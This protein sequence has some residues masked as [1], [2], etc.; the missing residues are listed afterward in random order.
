MPDTTRP[1]KG[2]GYR[3]WLPAWRIWLYARALLLTYLLIIPLWFLLGYSTAPGVLA[4]DFIAFWAAA[5]L[6]AQG[7]ATLA[8]DP[9]AIHAV[10]LLA[11][12]DSGE[13]PWFYPPPL[14]L[15]LWPLHALDYPTAFL[16]FS[17]LGT[18]FYALAI[19]AL[20]QRRQLICLFLLIPSVFI[21][22][23]YGQNGLWLS[24]MLAMALAH[25]EKRPLLSGLM[26][27]SLVIKPHLFLLLPLAL[28]TTR[29]HRPLVIAIITALLWCALSTWV[30]GTATWQAFHDGIL[31]ARQYLES[32]ELQWSQMAS[33]FSLSR[34]LGLDVTTSYALHAGS[35]LLGILALLAILR[36]KPPRELQWTSALLA[37]LMLSPFV[38]QYDLVLLTLP[39]LCLIQRA[40]TTGWP[41][42]QLEALLLCMALPGVIYAAKIPL[43]FIMSPLLLTLTWRQMNHD[44]RGGH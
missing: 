19:G 29:E 11:I 31:L 1:E 4:R 10:E 7:A 28:I 34:W 30:L 5:Q 24:A 9:A 16:L 13:F 41:R 17:V 3:G 35:F 15:L 33:T 23:L 27:G 43:L 6:A 26:L 22:L 39:M 32:G 2:Y 44:R 14:M 42:W 38:Y 25:G 21:T 36:R 20:S 12:A 40:L 8:Y 37:S 18:A